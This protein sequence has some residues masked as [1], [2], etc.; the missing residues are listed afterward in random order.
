MNKYKSLAMALA[1]AMA[2]S[3]CGNTATKPKEE[4]KEEVKQEET[5]KDEK[6]TESTADIATL[7]GDFEGTAKGYGGDINVKVTMENGVI[8]GI[9]VDQKETGAVGG[10]GILRIK[11]EVIAKNTTDLDNVSGATIS[12]AAFLS[13][14]NNAIKEAGANPEDL[15]AKESKEDRQTEITTDTVVVGAGGAGL[16]A[17]IQMAQ[18][19]KNVTVV[20][21]AGITGGNSSL[22]SGGMNAAETKLQK[23]EGIP[24]TV[25]TFVADTM[26]GGHDKNNKELVEKMAAESSEA[27]D[28]L[29]ELGAP[30]KQLKFSGGQTEMRTH[31]PINDEGKSIPVG[32]YLVQK[33]TE[34]AKEL[35]VEI[36]YDARVEKVLME[37][38]KAVGVEAAYKDG[39]KLRVNAGAVIVATGGFGSNQEM[40][41]KYNPDLKGYVSTNAKAFV[42]T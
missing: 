39:E 28:W 35:G 12:S 23:E 18:D 40:V 14:V 19:G 17:A 38:G 30:L 32:N 25:E 36:V 16:S 5:A 37:D 3:A 13:A 42:D 20:E 24:D 41:E 4:T 15:V 11:E 34:K 7:S 26:K 8:T 22:A 10:A 29:E 1:M 27:V 31:A 9:D 33:L 2:L 6:E 21:K